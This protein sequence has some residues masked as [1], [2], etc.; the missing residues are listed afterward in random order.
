MTQE[1]MSG[2]NRIVMMAYGERWRAV[3]KVMHQI[4]NIRSKDL[5]KDFQELESIQ[6]LHEYLQTPEKWYLSNQR[7]SN[8]VMLSVVF[9][10]R[11]QLDDPQ[12]AELFATSNEFLEN[13]QP[14]YNLVDGYPQLA[15]LP[16]FLQWWRPRGERAYHRTIR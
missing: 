1:I 13:L 15:K 14:G 11:A 6:L 12:I 3:R 2:G 9:G 10:R 4:L 7:Y 8:A 16:Q 5:Y